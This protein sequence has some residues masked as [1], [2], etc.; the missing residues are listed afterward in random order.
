M[1]LCSAECLRKLHANLDLTDGQDDENVFA[2]ICNPA[3]LSVRSIAS[4]ELS[5]D[6]WLTPVLSMRES[7]HLVS[8][9]ES[10]INFVI[11]V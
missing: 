9:R 11:L 1:S 3:D 10:S 4:P 5:D 6:Q 7:S 8:S 2:V